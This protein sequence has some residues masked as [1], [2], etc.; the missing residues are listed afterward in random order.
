MDYW[1]KFESLQEYQASAYG[2][3]PDDGTLPGKVAEALREAL[4]IGICPSDR[5]FDRLLPR[6]LQIIS[7]TYWT[8]LAVAM[9]AAQW[10][11]ECNVESVID[12]GSGAGKFCVAAALSGRAHFV[13][14]E[15][16]ASLIAAARDLARLLDVSERV[17]FLHGT[18][19]ETRL[20]EADAYYLF[21]PFGENLFGPEDV[22]DD[23]VQLGDAR[24]RRD[25]AAV[26]ELLRG[27]PAGTLVLI[28]NGFGGS[29]PASYQQIRVDQ[30]MPCTLRL[31]RKAV[32]P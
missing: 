27:A 31:W 9:R 17:K 19:G 15:Q 30:T 21:N 5:A 18:F 6:E 16:R 20:P 13:G 12:I 23:A 29:V 26:E 8:P 32:E 28:Y 14:L 4:S 22:L 7:C 10:F 1:P 11:D 25:I 3:A 2:L 24:Y